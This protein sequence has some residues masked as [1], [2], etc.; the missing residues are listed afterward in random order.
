MRKAPKIH[1]LRNEMPSH[2]GN[3]YWAQPVEI[4][5]HFESICESCIELHHHP[6]APTR[7][8]SNPGPDFFWLDWVV[9]SA[10]GP[11]RIRSAIK[12]PKSAGPSGSTQLEPTA[13]IGADRVELA[14]CIVAPW[15]LACW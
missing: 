9:G 4:D 10:L 3:G 15:A 13:L 1:K 2:L 7:W 6:A 5:R 12:R 14:V 8:G 11:A